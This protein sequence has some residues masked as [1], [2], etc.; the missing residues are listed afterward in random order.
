MGFFTGRVTF[1][2]F[3]VD[4]PTPTLFGP[5][6]LEKLANHAIGKQAVAEKDG[7]EVGWIASDDILDLGFDLAKNVV[8]D[9]LH[10]CLR[11]DTQKLPADLLRSY[12]RAELEALAAQNPSGR[13]APNRRRTPVKRPARSWRP[14]RRT[15]GSSAARHT[16]CCGTGRR[17]TCWSARP[18]PAFWTGCRTCFK[19]TFGC[20][21]VLADAGQRAA[22]GSPCRGPE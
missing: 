16:R 22:L 12:A 8:N 13:P 21:L 6:H 11:I 18:R 9:T 19:E 5:E 10:C 14:R 2:R 4:G 15:G 7:T 20:G 1:L 17:T 3:R